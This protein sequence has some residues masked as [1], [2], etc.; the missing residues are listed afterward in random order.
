VLDEE[1]CQYKA[2]KEMPKD[3]KMYGWD[4]KKEDWVELETEAVLER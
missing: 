3:G 1:K 4:E 2:P